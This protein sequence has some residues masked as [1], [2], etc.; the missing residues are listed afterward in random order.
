MLGTFLFHSAPPN[1]VQMFS[2]T[3]LGKMHQNDINKK[4][5]GIT[6]WHVAQKKKTI[7][8]IKVSLAAVQLQSNLLTQ[9]IFS[10]P[11]LLHQQVDRRRQGH[12]Q[13][14]GLRSPDE[15]LH[16][17]PGSSRRPPWSVPDDVVVECQGRPQGCQDLL[18]DAQERFK[19]GWKGRPQLNR[20]VTV[21]A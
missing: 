19:V 20:K 18:Q 4:V 17:G 2:D 15:V 8:Y 11:G 13:V 16:P 3:M 7:R 9:L 14:P 10:L 6:E 21:N 5:K 1:T 12:G